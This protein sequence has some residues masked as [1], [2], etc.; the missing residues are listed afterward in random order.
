M[1]KTQENLRIN[2]SQGIDVSQTRLLN[3]LSEVGILSYQLASIFKNFVD[4][5]NV[6]CNVLEYIKKEN[7]LKY[8][9]K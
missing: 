9:I 2:I 3:Y 1:K 4:T 7:I 5:N 8:E 6:I